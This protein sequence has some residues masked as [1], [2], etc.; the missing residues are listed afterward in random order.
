[1]GSVADLPATCADPLTFTT[2]P[3]G[4]A[5]ECATP[6]T[7]FAHLTLS[8][9]TKTHKNAED[10]ARI[11]ADPP[12]IPNVY[13]RIRQD[14]SA[15]PSSFCN[16]SH[17]KRSIRIIA[18]SFIII[19]IKGRCAPQGR[20]AAGL[21]SFKKYYKRGRLRRATVLTCARTRS[22]VHSTTCRVTLEPKMAPGSRL[23][24]PV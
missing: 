20:T 11:R 9:T 13:V 22:F 19:L 10:P 6:P 8:L 3:S 1:M 21:P 2:D 23:S 16:T 15:D 17:A 12:R 4:S 24:P 14:P 5:V 7:R 18:P